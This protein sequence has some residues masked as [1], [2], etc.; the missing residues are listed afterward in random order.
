MLRTILWFIFFWLYLIICIPAAFA[1]VIINRMGD[2]ISGRYVL[3]MTRSWARSILWAAGA[4]MTV[5]G[6]ENLPTHNR[7]CFIANHQG[8]FDIP[9][10]I[11][12][13]PRTFGFIAK[14][15]LSYIPLLRSWIKAIHCILINRADKRAAVDVIARGAENIRKDWAMAIFPEGTRSRCDSMHRF[16]GGSLK[17]ALRAEATIVPVTING[18]YKLKEANGDRIHG[19]SV[20]VTIHPPIDTAGLSREDAAELP[21]QLQATI[22]SALPPSP[23]LD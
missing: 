18:S 17:L 4:R 11:A 10:L 2:T 7:I 16:K 12:A 3:F 21:E 9:I 6:V 19:A 15:E 5:T 1:L 8:G 20:V 22:A 23:L 14:K 13:L